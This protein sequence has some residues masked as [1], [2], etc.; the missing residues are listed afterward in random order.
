MRARSRENPQICKLK[1]NKVIV[2][3]GQDIQKKAGTERE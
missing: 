1:Q 2:S 3:E